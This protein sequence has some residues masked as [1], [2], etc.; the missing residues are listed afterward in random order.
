MAA[1]GEGHIVAHCPPGGE[2]KKGR[3]YVKVPPEAD[4]GYILKVVE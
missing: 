3:K 2:V 1:G 4:R